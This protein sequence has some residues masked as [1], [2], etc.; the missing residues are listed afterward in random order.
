[1]IQYDRTSWWKTLFTFHGTVLPSVLGRVG[2][3][4][5]FSLA[6]S[7]LDRY[8]GEIGYPLPALDQLGHTVLGTALGM[9]IV[10]RTNSSN[11][12][13]W[14]GRACWGS[15]TN[16]SRN[17]ARLAATYASP[18]EPVANLI[19]AYMVVI[20]ENL[21]GSRNFTGLLKLIPEELV[22]KAR[23]AN[24][25]P[26]VIA[27]ALSQ[28]IGNRLKEGRIDSRQAMT[29]ELVLNTLVDNQGACERIQRTPLPF[30][31]AA[32]IKQI[33][34]IY[35]ATLPFVLVAKMGFA[36]PLVVAVVSFGMLGIEEAG[37]EIE[38]PFE[39]DPNGLPLEQICSTIALD[40]SMVCA[41][42][43]DA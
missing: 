29:M 13:Y 5:G 19:T 2:L 11:S 33:L 17:L 23:E 9:L 24:N 32:L 35:L 34:F 3:L 12:R 42:N 18:A 21:R 39:T 38:N 15:L 20:R 37:I 4:T 26:T 41:P 22:T 36:A 30:I 1:V 27:V 8:L 40:V 25:P 7:I 43:A 31:Y 6:L 16:N 28:W 10:F 14:D